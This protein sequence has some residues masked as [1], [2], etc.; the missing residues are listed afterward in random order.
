VLP[1]I[2]TDE[3]TAEDLGAANDASLPAAI[4]GGGMKGD[5]TRR[6]PGCHPTSTRDV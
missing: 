4:L 6:G 2:D 5:E 3:V 1:P